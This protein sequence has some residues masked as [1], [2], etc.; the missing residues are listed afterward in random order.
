MRLTMASRSALIL[1]ASIIWHCVQADAKSATDWQAL[2]HADLDAAHATIVAAHPGVIDQQNPAFNDWVETGY[3]QA[4]ELVPQAVDYESLLSVVRY[5]ATGFR[6]GHLGY[7]DD[8]RSDED[9]ITIDG[10]RLALK[11]GKYAVDLLA[12]D[13]PVPLPPLDSEWLGCDNHSPKD[14][15]DTDVAPFRT[16]QEGGEHDEVRA[17]AVWMRFLP[18]K[19]F[20]HCSF[21][22]SNESTMDL[23]IEYRALK[24]EPYF[25]LISRKSS[26]AHSSCD[27]HNAYSRI[28]DILW[29][30]TGNFSFHDDCG[31]AME[32]D[33]LLKRLKKEQHFSTI[34]FDVRGNNGGDSSIGD[35]IFDAATG[36]LKFD[37]SNMNRLP[38]T[39]AQWRVSEVLISTAKRN[40]ETERKLYGNQSEQ[41]QHAQ[42][43]YDSVQSAKVKGDQWLEQPSG[44]RVTSADVAARHG[45][46]RNFRG[47]VAIVTDSHCVSACLDFVDDIKQVPNSLQLGQTTGSDTVYIDT[48]NVRLP[49]GNHFWLP[50]KV[51]RNRLRANNEA[52]VPDIPLDVNMRD[53]HAVQ[54]SVLRAIS[55][56]R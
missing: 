33:E 11:D 27:R 51:W 22:A 43:F 17:E 19:E 45:M 32:L 42:R 50:L 26:T 20:H 47:K 23:P 38:R 40:A 34:V 25:D 53:D 52:Y 2:A 12:D 49:S 5:Y 4:L 35:R 6:D 24:T 13:W 8:I 1:A 36:G 9:A 14:I 39:Y 3:R 55:S 30:H 15:I 18:N 31:D 54:S 41:A 46:L 29:I 7:S 10:W 21:R 28:G 37:H 56:R 16:R 48:G 44:Y